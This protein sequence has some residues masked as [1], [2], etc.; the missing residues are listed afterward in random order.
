MKEHK[1]AHLLHTLSLLYSSAAQNSGSIANEL[2][3]VSILYFQLLYGRFYLAISLSANSVCPQPNPPHTPAGLLPWSFLCCIWGYYPTPSLE[4]Y[5]SVQRITGFLSF[6]WDSS[7]GPPAAELSFL[8]QGFH[9]SGLWSKSQVQKQTSGREEGHW[10]SG[11]RGLTPWLQ[12][13]LRN[14]PS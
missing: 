5:L 3:G 4:T 14:Q 6:P 7:W 8:S 10:G 12:Q 11:P 1:Q 2:T 13:E 9:H